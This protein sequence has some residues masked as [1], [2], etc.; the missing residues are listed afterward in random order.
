MAMPQRQRQD[1]IDSSPLRS[2]L[3]GRGAARSTA[4]KTFFISAGPQL[5]VTMT[6]PERTKLG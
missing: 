5:G 2:P 3:S 1:A 6:A 4:L